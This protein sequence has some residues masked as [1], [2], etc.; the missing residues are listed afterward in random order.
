M[1][2]KTQSGVGYAHVFHTLKYVHIVPFKQILSNLCVCADN[3]SK[4]GSSAF[5]RPRSLQNTI[6][7]FFI[8]IVDYPMFWHDQH[9][10]ICVCYPSVDLSQRL[11][12]V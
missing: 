3:F 6:K 4:L 10:R 1:S 2:P 8:H 7:I 9:A 5:F 12:T 11:G